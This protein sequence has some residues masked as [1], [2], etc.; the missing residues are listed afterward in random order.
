MKAMKKNLK[1]L[2]VILGIVTGFS[3]MGLEIMIGQVSDWIP[4]ELEYV[5]REA[6]EAKSN[7]HYVKVEE[8]ETTVGRVLRGVCLCN[9]GYRVNNSNECI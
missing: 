6:C 2:I 8:D 4:I 5:Y 3:C 1:R 7:T 9:M